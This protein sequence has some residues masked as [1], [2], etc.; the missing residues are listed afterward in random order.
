MVLKVSKGRGKTM[1]LKGIIK[2]MILPLIVISSIFL[3]GSLQVDAAG[4]TYYVSQ[5]GNDANS[6]AIE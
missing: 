4:H 2:K 3:F 6:G 5:S 1:N